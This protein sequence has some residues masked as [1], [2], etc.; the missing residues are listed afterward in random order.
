MPVHM[1]TSNEIIRFR[2]LQDAARY[3]FA[4]YETFTIFQC[5]TTPLLHPKYMAE[6]L[7]RQSGISRRL[8]Q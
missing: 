4:F 7:T 1:L 3:I 2:F 5:N 8:P 6:Y